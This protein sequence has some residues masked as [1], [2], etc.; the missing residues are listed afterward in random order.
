MEKAPSG[1]ADVTL[2]KGSTLSGQSGAFLNTG[3]TANTA[4]PLGQTA[5]G[6]LLAR[7]DAVIE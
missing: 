3:T 7:A 1:A 5:P 4:T 6:S 2:G